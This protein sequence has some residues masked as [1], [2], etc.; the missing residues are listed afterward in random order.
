MAHSK[1]SARQSTKQEKSDQK[2]NAEAIALARK[3]NEAMKLAEWLELIL[4][5]PA[6]PDQLHSDIVDSLNEIQSRNDCYNA[7]FLMGL[8][9]SEPRKAEGGAA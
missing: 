8:L 9:L 4:K 5:I 3:H 1:L 2:P 6:C 7:E